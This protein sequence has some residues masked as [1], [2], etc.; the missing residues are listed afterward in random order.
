MFGALVINENWGSDW[1]RIFSYPSPT[2][3]NDRVRNIQT[4]VDFSGRTW[5]GEIFG[6]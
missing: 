1:Q 6:S 4:N 5:Y 2:R 3:Q